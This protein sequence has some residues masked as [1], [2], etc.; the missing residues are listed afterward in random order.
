MELTNCI[1]CKRHL[2]LYKGNGIVECQRDGYIVFA[3]I[4]NHTKVDCVDFNNGASQAIYMGK[5]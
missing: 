1:T 2:Y 4:V 5:I 3:P